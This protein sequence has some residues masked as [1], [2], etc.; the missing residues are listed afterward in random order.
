[1][2]IASWPLWYK[3]KT[4]AQRRA[5]LSNWSRGRNTWH[6]RPG[7]VMAAVVKTSALVAATATSGVS[8]LAAVGGARIRRRPLRARV[9]CTEAASRRVATRQST[10]LFPRFARVPCFCRL[11]PSP[12]DLRPSQLSM[13][14]ADPR[15]TC[16][17]RSRR[18]RPTRRL[19]LFLGS[20]RHLRGS[21]GSV[22]H[23][24]T[25]PPPFSSSTA[26]RPTLIARTRQTTRPAQWVSHQPG[27]AAVRRRRRQAACML[28]VRTV[29]VRQP[30]WRRLG[31][32]ACATR[33]RMASDGCVFRSLC[34]CR[35]APSGCRPCGGWPRSDTRSHAIGGWL[36]SS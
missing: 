19:Q 16:R 35:Q 34:S 3:P 5:V 29:A 24:S 11:S 25:P 18:P 9:S 12:R 13:R 14:G 31:V 21:I 15:C 27:L 7:L 2:L 36:R 1:M 4:T 8:G 6:P 32:F 20:T 17:R 33:R 26:A 28:A 22:P 23:A 10:S 30:L